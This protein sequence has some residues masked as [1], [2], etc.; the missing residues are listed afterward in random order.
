MHEHKWK[1]ELDRLVKTLDSGTQPLLRT[2]R[3]GLKN[4]IESV[5]I[6]IEISS[7]RAK[8]LAADSSFTMEDI[9]KSLRN[10]LQNRGGAA[11]KQQVKYDSN[12][13]R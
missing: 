13:E 10:R 3:E 5:R 1:K 12:S 2:D 11:S 7:A 9:D 4:R 8:W 6:I